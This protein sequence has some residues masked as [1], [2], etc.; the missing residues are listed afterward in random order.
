MRYSNFLIAATLLS[1]A[2]SSTADGQAAQSTRAGHR[3]RL[4]AATQI[5]LARSAAPASVSDHASVLVLTDTGYVRAVAGESDVTCLVEH[6]WR[7]SIEPHC[8]DAEGTLTSLRAEARRLQLREAGKSEDEVARTVSS[9]IAAGTLRLPAR[10]VLSYMMS[11]GQ[12]LYNDDGKYMG[13]LPSHLMIYYPNLTNSAL[14]LGSTPQGHVGMV[15]DSGKP[16]SNLMIVMGELLPV[17]KAG[18]A[19]AGK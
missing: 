7:D 6:S 14:G 2:N 17:A 9:E 11:A 10:P 4:P 18:S 3:V 15:M 13:A 12:V 16:G 5:A 1:L 8:Y 19:K